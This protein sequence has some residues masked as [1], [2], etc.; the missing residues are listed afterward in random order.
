[1]IRNPRS[2][3]PALGAVALIGLMLLPAAP[4]RA[5][6]AVDLEARAM[7]G[8]R[9]EIG[10][11]LAVAVTLVNDGTPTEGWLAADTDAGSVRRFV[12]M[13]AGARK[14]VTLYVQPG[15]FQREV[16]VRYEEPNGTNRVTVQVSV[17]EQT[18]DQVAIVGDGTGALRPQ[19]SGAGVA[20]APDPIVIGAADVPDRPEPLSGLATI[21]WAADSGPLSEAQRRGL[22]RWIA[23]GGQ[24][25]VLGGADW[26]ARTAAFG[27]LLPLEGLSSIDAVSQAG[28]ASWAGSEA[29]AVEEATVAVGTARDGARTLATADDGTALITL[30]PFG[31]GRVVLIGSD[32]GVEDYRGW[33]GAPGLWA[34][35]LPTNALLAG[36]FGVP[37][38][39]RDLTGGAMARALNTLP[40][41]D[42]PAGELLL[43]V[44]IAYI[45]LIG[46]VS[47]LVLGRLDRRELAWVTAPLLVIVFSACSYG[48]GL[49]LRGSDL[50]VNQIAI[51]RSSAAGSTA[52]VETYAGVFSPSRA[53][54]DVV[55]EADALLG[56][57]STASLDGAV[58]APRPG[59][60]SEQGDPARLRDLGIAAAGFEYLR[61]DG[62]LDH[63][64]AMSVS[65]SYEGGNVVGTVTNVG[66]VA[67]ADVAY[68]SIGG[69]EMIGD[70][71]PGESGRF[72]AERAGFNQA[73]ASDQVYG[74]GGMDMSDPERRRI[75]ARRSVIDSLVGFGSWMPAGA[76]LGGVSGA[77]PFVIGWQAGEGPMPILVEGH[78][79]QRYA[80]VA[81]VVSI[82]PGLGRGEVVIGPGQLGVTVTGDG[83]VASTGPATVAIARGSA[84]FGLSLP[85]EASDMAVE[86]VAIIIGPDPTTVLTDPGGFGGFWPAGYLVELRDAET[87]EWIELGDLAEQ[88]RFEIADAAAA[89]S[90]TGRIE[91]RVTAAEESAGLGQNNIFVSAEIAGV[92]DE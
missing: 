31:A 88:S 44:I 33:E 30:L 42:V 13:P 89:V 32:L 80:E 9:F 61:A 26:Q 79:P 11:W 92:L 49:S 41:L 25:I 85:L 91:V 54:V 72:E 74:F 57:M 6:S 46:P 67:L 50:I 59:V 90:D 16:E 47:Y 68:I 37:M 45:L 5:A 69:G 82:Q 71:A 75:V 36:A 10:G 4:A 43:A 56:R 17:F 66:E 73:S 24:L 35:L 21:V 22:E 83:D 39:D 18:G 14:A 81:E 48:I 76:E 19:L 8:G 86:E 58:G 78:E 40:T 12:E 34:R 60:A 52:T 87:G 62:V 1:M 63:Q 38:P 2:I 7:L 28:L 70:L 27:D 29:P 65:W 15:G 20:D 77:G 3:L 55:V 53:N 64:P 23:D 84:T 51:V